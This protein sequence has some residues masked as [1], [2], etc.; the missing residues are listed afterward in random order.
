MGAA[1]RSISVEPAAQQE[2]RID[3]GLA[4]QRQNRDAGRN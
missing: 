4:V 3:A 1:F 2:I